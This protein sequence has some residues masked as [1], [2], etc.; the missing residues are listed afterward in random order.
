M[1]RSTY[2][3]PELVQSTKIRVRWDAVLTVITAGSLG[4]VVGIVLTTAVYSAV[5]P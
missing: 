5:L 1:M 3:K 4:I 2:R